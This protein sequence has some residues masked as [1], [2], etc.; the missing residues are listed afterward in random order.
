MKM[1]KTDR[2]ENKKCGQC[3]HFIGLGDFCLCCELKYDLVNA[4]TD[5][6]SQFFEG[7]YKGVHNSQYEN[8]IES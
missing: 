6:C 7:V 2:L 8:S 3:S 5:A 1:A 4:D